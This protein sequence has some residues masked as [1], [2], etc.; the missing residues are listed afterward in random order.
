MLIK[1]GFVE[2]FG[3][4]RLQRSD[5]YPR[6]SDEDRLK[7]KKHCLTI[8]NMNRENSCIPSSCPQ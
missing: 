5:A 4:Y 7:W 3:K 8:S 6:A 2:I 1:S